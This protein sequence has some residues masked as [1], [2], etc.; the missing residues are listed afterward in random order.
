MG[1]L[2]GCLLCREFVCFVGE[3]RYSGLVQLGDTKVDSP[4]VRNEHGV[5]LNVGEFRTNLHDS[6]VVEVEL[7]VLKLWNIRPS[8]AAPPNSCDTNGSH[9]YQLILWHM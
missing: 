7:N 5:L 6:D 2:P 1:S 8:K 4:N 9:A 3:N